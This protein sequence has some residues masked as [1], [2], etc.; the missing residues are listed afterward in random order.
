MKLSPGPKTKCHCG[1]NAG[2][3]AVKRTLQPFH[4]KVWFCSRRCYEQAKEARRLKLQK[5]LDAQ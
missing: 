5:W 2:L 4:A 1:R 3:G